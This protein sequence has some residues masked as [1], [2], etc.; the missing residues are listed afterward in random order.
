MN[1][2]SNIIQV[3]EIQWDIDK[4]LINNQKIKKI[5]E[6][7]SKKWLDEMQINQV[8]SS[9]NTQIDYINNWIDNHRVL[10][11][12]IDTWISDFNWEIQEW[13]NAELVLITKLK[14][15]FNTQISDFISSINNETVNDLD[16]L[17]SLFSNISESSSIKAILDN[18]KN[19][20]IY[21]TKMLD[22][23]QN[24]PIETAI[25]NYKQRRNNTQDIKSALYAILGW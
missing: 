8:L 24:D 18:A 23:D 2:V 21:A 11:E 25:N 9:I 13:T 7:L 16:N 6:I 5:E 15:K 22:I 19:K 17:Y 12:F 3:E 4:L 1:E 14:D 20:R 10:D